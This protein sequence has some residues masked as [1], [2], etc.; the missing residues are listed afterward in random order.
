MLFQTWRWPNIETTL[1]Q[2]LVFAG[3]G[4]PL[5]CPGAMRQTSVGKILRERL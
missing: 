5:L 4:W 1:G 2:V 3:R